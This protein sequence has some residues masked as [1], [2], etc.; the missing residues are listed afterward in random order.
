MAWLGE[1][2]RRFAALLRRNQLAADLEDEMHL[3][4][5]LRA[6]QEA[7]AG[8]GPDQA[9]YAAERRF[10]NSLL[11]KESSRDAWG[12]HWLETFV[13]DLRYALRTLRRSAGFTAAAVLSLALGIGANTAIFTLINAL[14]LKT[15]PVP[16]PQQ[17]VWLGYSNLEFHDGHSFPYPF[18]RELRDRNSVFSGLACY[19][20][21]TPAFGVERISGELVSGNYFDVLQVKPYIGRLFTRG[22]ER[23][24]GAERIAVLSYGFWVRRFGADPGIIGKVIRLNS[25]PMTVIGVSSPGF[26][27]LDVSPPVDVRVPIV[28]QAEMWAVTSVL[29]NRDDWWMYQVGRLK[30][31]ITRVQA[32]ASIQPMLASYLQANS[33]AQPDEYR[34]RLLKSEHIVLSPMA[35]GEQQLGR[36]FRPALYVLMSVV[37]AVLLIACVNIANLLLARSTAREREVAIR[38]AIGAA[39]GRLI[40][41]MLTE[42]LLLAM[43]G[44]A[45]GVAV[46]YG[47]T[48]VLIASLPQMDRV[49]LDLTPDL[50]VLGFT[51]A[52]SIISGALFGLG[53]AL[54]SVRPNVSPG[55]KAEKGSSSGIFTLGRIL[56]SAQVALLVLLLTGAGLFAR[57][58]HN[59]YTMDLSFNREN[60][61]VL[62]LDAT[63]SGYSQERV[64]R[65]YS[66][67][68]E[69]VSALP[70][71][72]AATYASIGLMT[73]SDWGSGIRI[74]GYTRP[75][76]DRGPD[77][78]VV[79]PAYFRTLGIPLVLGRDFGSSDRYNSPHVAI[80]N[81]K[82]AHFY[83]GD[84]NPIGRRIGPEGDDTPPDY[85]IV[86]VAKDGKYATM[87]EQTPRFWYIPYEQL[88]EVHD[89]RLY[90]RCAGNAAAMISTLRKAI[91]SVDPNVTVDDP[92]TLE[93]QIDE[94]LSTD[95]LL[96]TLSAF[97]SALAVLLA[98]IGLY[99]VMA[100]TVVRR[101]HDIGI[102]MALGAG[103]TDVLWLVLR[104]ALVLV[105]LGIA[106]GVPVT[107]ALTRLAS[108]LLYGLSPADPLT[109]SAAALVMFIV[110]AVAGYLPARRAARLDPLVALH[111]E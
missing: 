102:R 52:V 105:M 22:D 7:E 100:Y 80:V 103:R 99:G 31:G 62:S 55:L 67:A 76:G 15:L 39:R 54:Q 77:R 29:E 101:T 83:F 111:Y 78:N 51:F 9:R 75:G 8:T 27:G 23:A 13:Q 63:L 28:M 3:H 95:R 66:D 50:R 65:F 88:R 24:P 73:H 90:V 97:F 37:A 46:A 44:G 32:E 4:I 45:L 6:Q 10:G 64:R 38:L 53:P 42:S 33:R 11:L 70:G 81:E 25:I 106:A 79:G 89:L 47:G 16:D 72:R 87:R 68:L 93:L 41:Q 34:R 91:Q 108:S 94:D 86:G 36:H 17:L 109:L 104:Q 74:P 14:L 59:L 30:P 18:Y 56:V 69:R 40:R 58:L 2:W 1:L 26:D 35:R 5:E 98:S 21:M 60:T 49:I 110:A 96:A 61:A 43:L 92:K 71:V 20:G 48:R 57:S 82:F 107:L 85:T 12:W 19:T 84:Q